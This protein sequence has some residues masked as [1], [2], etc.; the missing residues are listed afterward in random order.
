MVKQS[1]GSY[2]SALV[3]GFFARLH[4]PSLA[5]IVNLRH[6][7]TQLS[8][9]LILVITQAYFQIVKIVGERNHSSALASDVSSLEKC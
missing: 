1:P 7:I 4:P 9:K 8:K 5:L 6:W 3:A 2:D